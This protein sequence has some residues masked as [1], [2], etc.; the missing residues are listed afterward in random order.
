MGI[1]ISKILV[2]LGKDPSSFTLMT[3]L[4]D[5]DKVLGVMISWVIMCTPF[6]VC[7][8]IIAAIGVHDDLAEVFKMVGLLIGCAM[9][10]FVMQVVFVYF[11][12]YVFFIKKSPRKYLRA[13]APAQVLAFCSASSAAT[14]PV[15]IKSA[16][17]SG[18]VP[19]AVANFVIPLGATVNMD[20]SAIYFPCACIWLAIYNG[21]KPT[22]V[23]YVLLVIIATFGTMGTAPVP[24]ASLKLI[25]TA[26]NTVFNSTGTPDGFSYIF[27]VD[28]FMDRCRTVVNVT[29]DT[30][31]T[32]IISHIAPLDDRETDDETEGKTK[33]T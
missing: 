18:D 30:F 17:S 23:D 16:V 2:R 31:V 11:G 22:A 28:W 1:A 7:S 6:A 32:A 10:A 5:I 14:V 29:G 24:S 25:V 3:L 26:Y 13:I 27:A 20:G 21:I 8:L 15:S 4:M 12:L 19:H 9:L 33:A